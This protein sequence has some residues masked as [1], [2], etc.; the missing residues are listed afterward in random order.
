MNQLI[1]G[2]LQFSKVE[3]N[4]KAYE[5]TDMNEMVEI[6]KQN[7]DQAIKESGATITNDPLP[8]IVADPIQM[9]QL[10]QNLIANAIKFRKHGEPPRVH[11]SVQG[12]D[13]SWTF[14]V[15]DNGIGIPK[16]QQGR[17]FEM[18]QRL[19]AGEEYEGTGIG[20]AFAKKITERHGGRIWVESEEGK[21]AAFFFTIPKSG[22]LA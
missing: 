16:E 18:F 19:D 20:L 17:I 3:S 9:V 13:L 5:L 22:L 21:G 14:S 15:K 8:I 7:L 12:A 11:V 2:L 1:D 4:G 6:V 10:L